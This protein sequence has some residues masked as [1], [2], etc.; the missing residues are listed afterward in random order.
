[1]GFSRD[2]SCLKNGSYVPFLW[3]SHMQKQYHQRTTLRTWEPWRTQERD[4][5]WS[6]PTIAH[7]IHSTSEPLGMTVAQWDD[8]FWDWLLLWDACYMAGVRWGSRCE[9]FLSKEGPHYCFEQSARNPTINLIHE[10]GNPL[11]IPHLQ[12]PVFFLVHE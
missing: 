10:F 9:G 8:V 7:H 5:E 4:A 2:Q 11:G 3:G 6:A 1:M 12:E